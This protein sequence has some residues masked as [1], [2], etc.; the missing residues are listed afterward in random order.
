MANS[1]NRITTSFCPTCGSPLFGRS[2]GFPGMVGFRVASL[3]DS[4][5][6]APQFAV[7]ASRRQPWDD[8]VDGLATFPEMPPRQPA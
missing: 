1:G 2:P 4:G 8:V 5:D 6:L 3:D 7:F